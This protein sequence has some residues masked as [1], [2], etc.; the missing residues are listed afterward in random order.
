MK[1]FEGCVLASD[2]DGTLINNNRLCSRN[3][4][5]I[6]R[7]VQAGGSFCL[8]SGRS[9]LAA[10]PIAEE[11]GCATLSV[12]YNGGMV[13]DFSN[14]AVLSEKTLDPRAKQFLFSL[15]DRFC[16]IGAEA[17]VKTD[18]YIVHETQ[19]VLD[20]LAYESLRGL[21]TDRD[22]LMRLPW[23]K[24]LAL[25]EDAR[26]C[27]EVC[28][29]A[30]ELGL[31]CTF[32]ESSCCIDGIPRY[33]LEQ[34]PSGTDKAAGVKTMLSFLSVRKGGFFAIGDYDNDLGMLQ[35]ADCAASVAD[36]PEYIRK[37]CNFVGGTCQNGAVADFIEY[38]FQQYRC[39]NAS[40][41]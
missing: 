28:R 38:L 10:R 30:Q 16:E 36:A 27:R 25:F 20:H 37:Q 5:A 4:E 7:F 13:Y 24:A 9:P 40:E 29:E 39:G 15:T 3:L 11:I 33:Y 19:E 41:E 14:N 21:R 2:I 26:R 22:S 1:L 18:P 32:T 35:A 34:L 17:Y 6:H 12:L 8:A 23:N 31:P